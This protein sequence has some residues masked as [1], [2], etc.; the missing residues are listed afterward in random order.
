MKQLTSGGVPLLF[1]EKV[2]IVACWL[3]M[4]ACDL[5]MPFVVFSGVNHILV[6]GL[7]IFVLCE[8]T[9]IT[10]PHAR[11]SNPKNIKYRKIYHTLPW[12]LNA[13]VKCTSRVVDYHP[14]NTVHYCG[15]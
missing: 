9:G 14:K 10:T 6:R 15:G 8:L 13:A 11:E 5:D 1:K 2:V 7:V 12:W 3:R 4:S